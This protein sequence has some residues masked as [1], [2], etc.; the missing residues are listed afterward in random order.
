MH[1][2][3]A[4]GGVGLAA[5]AH[6]LPSTLE[7]RQNAT[8]GV[9]PREEGRMRVKSMGMVLLLL[10]SGP[11]GVVAQAPSFPSEAKR[12]TVDVVVTDGKG[13][14]IAGLTRE[15]FVVKENGAVQSILEFEAVDVSDS[16]SLAA[17]EEQPA[18][19]TNMVAP[20]EPGRSF[21]VVVDDLNLSPS[22]AERVK[23]SLAKFLEVHVRE[24]DGVTLA[25][26]AGGPWWTGRMTRDRDDLLAA[27]R[28][29]QGRR[30]P[31][32]R[33]ERMNDHEAM[34]IEVK[35]DR[36]AITHVTQRF[37][38]HGISAPEAAFAEDEISPLPDDRV[39]ALLDVGQG[40]AVVLAGAGE[41]YARAKE[42][43]RQAL[44]SLERAMT[45][46]AGGRGR[47]A[48]ILASDGF[49]QDEGLHEFQR[50]REAARRSNAAL[51]F[52]D[53]R[54]L[55]GR[56]FGRA[57]TPLAPDPLTMP[58]FTSLE[59]E[60]EAMTSAGAEALAADT[61]GFAIRNTNDLAAGLG[62]ISGESRTFYL[63]GYEPSDKRADGR[64][65]KIQVE[66]RRPGV[67]V[68][69]RRGYYADGGKR[70]AA[71]KPEAPLP[72]ELSA[73]ALR[74]LD[75]PNPERGIP[76]RMTAYVLGGA[77]GGRATV[78]LAAEADPSA[79]EL[80]DG[81][82]TLKGALETFSS[83]AARD[84]GEVARRER[85]VDLDLR[86][87]VRA[88]MASTWVPVIH[89]YELP[90]GRYQATLAVR[91]RRS[92]RVGSVR[93]DLE[94]P[95]LPGL[96]VTTPILTDA[97]QRGAEGAA[98]IPLPIARRAFAPGTRLVCAF[99]VEGARR[100]GA[101]GGPRVLITYE[102]RRRDGTV[103]TRAWPTPLPLDDTGA[104]SGRFSLTLNRPG[105]YEMHIRARDELSGEQAVAV[106]A[107][108]VEPS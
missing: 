95:R 69:A 11:P 100:G 28:A 103:V 45:A 63:L 85:F 78:L 35:R 44:R 16:R 66:V 4:G 25:P 99:A 86:P 47:R 61:G 18:V 21:L 2:A 1:S 7:S 92:G 97:L 29:V 70:E 87:E 64:Y 23:S 57:D 107:F 40:H 52:V 94:V 14:P 67:S 56:D 60:Y 26:T 102:V 17:V 58:N 10:A 73:A 62:R 37:A 36:E 34:L 9:E 42:R 104:L 68:R 46:L 5:E 31:D 98:P 19:A 84:T 53:A 77:T 105:E 22:S 8:A 83:L 65:R 76:V 90:P 3:S 59:L 43:T 39:S 80:V 24:G 71:A 51:Y 82:G 93:Y 79:L 38:L 15:D 6:F 88:Q 74:A 50:V 75:A 96:R 54:G 81:G 32:M 12:V 48:V 101:A 13:Q 108:V 49:M 20:E 106:Q 33:P 30:V 27:L 89:G 41:T 72:G 91:D 55:D